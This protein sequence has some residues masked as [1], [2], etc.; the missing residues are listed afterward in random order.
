M[1]ENSSRILK[2]FQNVKEKNGLII[3]PTDYREDS[4]LKEIFYNIQFNSFIDISSFEKELDKLNKERDVE[5]ILLFIV[6]K[7]INLLKKI[8]KSDKFAFYINEPPD[9]FH[10][11]YLYENINDNIIENIEQLYSE[12]VIKLIGENFLYKK[13]ANIY[14]DI[15]QLFLFIIP[16]KKNDKCIGSTVFLI[17]FNFD[18]FEEFNNLLKRLNNYFYTLIL[19]YI[20]KRQIEKSKENTELLIFT[21]KKFNY[22]SNFEKNLKVILKFSI[23]KIKADIGAIIFVNNSGKLYFKII[24]EGFF[25]R[26]IKRKWKVS[27]DIFSESIS[28]KNSFL[29]KDLSNDPRFNKTFNI[30]KGPIGSA[31]IVPFYSKRFKGCFSLFRE[32]KKQSFNR[33]DFNIISSIANVLTTNIDN[34]FL[35]REISNSYLQTT[36]SLASAIEAKDKYTKGHSLRV[37]RY[38]MMIGKELGLDREDLKIIRLSAIL[39]D[40]G[41]IG[42]PESIITKKG[43][44]NDEEFKIMMKHPIIGYEITKNIDYLKKGLPFILYHHEK[45]DGSGYPF[46]L[47]GD[48]IPLFA[49]IGSVADTFDAITSDRSYRKGLSFNEAVKE[50]RKFADIQFDKKIVEAFVKA[51]KKIY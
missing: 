20:L 2:F 36:L 12:G 42:I 7:Y 25:E 14:N 47:K 18:F 17:D 5:E 6:K 33:Y 4:L 21:G 19:E 26:I 46:G 1:D 30:F 41:K 37:M 32:I 44:L 10:E 40:I 28:K 16:L 23:D 35:Y 9:Y 48:K 27:D 22:N 38:A 31:I 39:H 51:L 13:I 8:I 11:L 43:P 24:S 34:L 49:R 15:E 29:V 45:I 50:L 3:L